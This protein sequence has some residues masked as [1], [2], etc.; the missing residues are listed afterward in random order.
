MRDEKGRFIKGHTFWKGK[1]HSEETKEK[2]SIMRMGK[3]NPMYGKKSWC[4]GTKGLVKPNKGSFKKGIH[5][6]IKTE[7]NSYNSSMEKNHA[8][9]GGK[10]FE[11]YT[12]EFNNKLKEKIRRRDSYTCQE[13]GFTQDKLGYKLSIHHI[14]YNKK[15]NNID[16][17]ICLCKSCHAQTNFKRGDWEAYFKVKLNDI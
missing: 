11:P 8:W 15:N 5:Y 16:N 9:A 13:C 12:I 4:N 14:D 2:L 7:F 1:K 17:L 6:S 3:N 10:S